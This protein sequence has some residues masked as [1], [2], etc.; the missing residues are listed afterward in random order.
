MFRSKITSFKDGNPTKWRIENSWGKDNHV[1]GY[2]CMSN[3]WFREF[4]F[5]I[6]IDKTHC[7]QDVL[8]VQ[9]K[10]PKMLPAWDPMGSLAR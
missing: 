6:V 5:E 2:I 3:E 4:V 8:D 9:E 1:E 7:T 10:P